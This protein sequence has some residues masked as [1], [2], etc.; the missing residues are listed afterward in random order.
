MDKKLL[1]IVISSALLSIVNVHAQKSSLKNFKKTNKYEVAVYYFPQWHVDPQNEKKYGYPWTEWE[2]L[3]NAKPRFEGHQQPKVPLWGY[4]DEADPKVM[5]KKIEVAS[6]H[7]I[8]I[9]LYDWYYRNN[10]PFLQRCLDEGFLKAKNKSKMKFAIMWANHSEITPSI[11]DSVINVCINKY[12]KDSSYWTVDGSPYFYIYQMYTF[13]SSFGSIEKAKQ[14]LNKFRE[15][16][17]AAG[18]KDLH[19]N[20]VQWGLQMPDGMPIKSPNELIDLFDINSVDTYVWIHHTDMPDFPTTS[21]DY[22]MQKAFSYWDSA[23]FKFKVPYHPNVT[24]GW[25]ASPRCD[26]NKPW[27]K[28]EYPYYSVLEGNTP[29]KFKQSLQRAKN[30]VDAKNPVHKIITINSWNEW[31]EGSYL[32]PDTINKMKY[33]ESV[34]EVFGAQS[35]NIQ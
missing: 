18:F 15:K 27:I 31:T 12:F 7:G 11:F 20:A 1:I 35:S 25:D 2:V 8:D 19:L 22:M 23:H 26:S 4:E 10:G 6:S 33:L 3:K 9:F 34:R 21:Y 16:T 28:G 32:E 17:K 29:D 30:F 24:M 13:I 5:A 14:A